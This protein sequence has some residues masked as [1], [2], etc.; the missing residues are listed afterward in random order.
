MIDF[1]QWQNEQKYSLGH[2]RAVPKT[3]ELSAEPGKTPLQKADVFLNGLH[4]SPYK[5][6]N[7]LHQRPLP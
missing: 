4:L 5:N 7:L 6:N 3:S 2:L 1:P